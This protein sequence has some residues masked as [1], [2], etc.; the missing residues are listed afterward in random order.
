VRDY[1]D[2]LRSKTYEKDWLKNYSNHDYG[3]N[4]VFD[5][6]NSN[7]LS[8]TISRANRNALNSKT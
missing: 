6:K 4:G 2:T 8:N 7:Y 3:K 5:K 1:F